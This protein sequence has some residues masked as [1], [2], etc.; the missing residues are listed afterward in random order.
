MKKGSI[1]LLT[2]CILCDTLIEY[3]YLEE[4]FPKY[5]FECFVKN[6]PEIYVNGRRV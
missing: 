3:Y 5:C 1:V 6:K 2:T 4:A